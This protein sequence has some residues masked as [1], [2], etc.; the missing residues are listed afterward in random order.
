ML[1]FSIMILGL[2]VADWCMEH[3]PTNSLQSVGKSSSMSSANLS[4]AADA[5]RWPLDAVSSSTCSSSSS[6]R[7][8]GCWVICHKFPW[9]C[10][11]EA[12]Q[13]IKYFFELFN[14]SSENLCYLK[15]ATTWKCLHVYLPWKMTSVTWNIIWRNKGFVARS[16][17][18]KKQCSGIQ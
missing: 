14:F 6:S 4:I 9:S 11:T 2:Q 18:M 5:T 3:S 1:I 8:L 10:E 16:H 13:F 15:A 17:R 12:W 7:C